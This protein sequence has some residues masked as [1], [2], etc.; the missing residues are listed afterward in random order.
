MR[1]NLKQIFDKVK[2]AP[3]QIRNVNYVC[4]PEAIYS[5][6]ENEYKEK[7]E[8]SIRAQQIMSWLTSQ[9]DSSLNRIK[10]YTQTFAHVES[11]LANYTFKKINFDGKDLN[12]AFAMSPGDISSYIESLHPFTK[13]YGSKFYAE[14]SV[15][16]LR[17]LRGKIVGLSLEF[18]K[19]DT[20]PDN[21]LAH[22]VYISNDGDN[23][24][25]NGEKVSIEK[26]VTDAEANRKKVPEADL[27]LAYDKIVYGIGVTK[28]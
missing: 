9:S 14:L 15:N 6:L 1:Q 24:F 18:R 11:G 8:S 27:D 28:F 12:V 7:P 20:N 26:F 5:L 3:Q 16:N 17:R 10:A 25:N 21:G 13:I 23:V 19:N 22:W 2:Q 4:G